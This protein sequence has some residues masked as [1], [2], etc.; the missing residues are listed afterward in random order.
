[1][2]RNNT[3]YKKLE[4]IITIF[5]ILNVVL[6]IAYMIFAGMGMTGLKITAAV[7]CI[8]ISAA[9]LYY[10]Y[11]TRELLRKRSIWMTLA[12]ACIIICLLFS[13]VLNF[14]APKFTLPTV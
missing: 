2:A 7:L 11:I 6:F 1:M 13:L 10:L 9:V 12:A 4:S 3:R 8:L 5:L 14:P